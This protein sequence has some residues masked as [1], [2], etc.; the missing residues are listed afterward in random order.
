MSRTH[1]VATMQLNW[2]FLIKKNY[3]N[4]KA[5]SWRFDQDKSRRYDQDKSQFF[6]RRTESKLETKLQSQTISKTTRMSYFKIH[7]LAI[8]GTFGEF[9]AL[10]NDDGGRTGDHK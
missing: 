2:N 10:N 6:P 3:K 5:T 4:S 7:G 1:P 9:R 8:T